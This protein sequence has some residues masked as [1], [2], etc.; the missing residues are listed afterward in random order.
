MDSYLFISPYGD[1]DLIFH[2]MEWF[3]GSVAYQA[4]PGY[5]VKLVAV[6]DERLFGQNGHKR[7]YG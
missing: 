2:Q 3:C 1:D 4:R 5:Y 7:G 6:I